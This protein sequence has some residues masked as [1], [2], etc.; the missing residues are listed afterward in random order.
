MGFFR[1]LGFGGEGGWAMP[2]L[3]P[4]PLGTSMPLSMLDIDDK[5]KL[6]KVSF[7]FLFFLLNEVFEDGFKG[8]VLR[9]VIVALCNP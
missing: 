1:V 6:Q 3:L 7:F 2:P 8:M 4:L 9:Y 5:R